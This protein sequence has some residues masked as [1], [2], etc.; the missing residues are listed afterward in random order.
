MS[1]G[2]PCRLPVTAVSVDDDGAEDLSMDLSM[3]VSDIESA[4]LVAVVSV[5]VGEKVREW[6]AV[7]VTVHELLKC[8]CRVL[9]GA[10]FFCFV[11]LFTRR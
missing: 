1:A 6:M 11:F 4:R 9:E 10:S 3:T 5:D 7:A 8:E 2:I